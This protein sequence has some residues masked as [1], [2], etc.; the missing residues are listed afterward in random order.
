[1]VFGDV[2]ARLV[3]VD[4]FDDSDVFQSALDACM[5]AV[6]QH[7]VAPALRNALAE[8]EDALLAAGLNPRRLA[9]ARQALQG[10]SERM[11]PKPSD[12]SEAAELQHNVP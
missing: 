5:P 2:V 6:I 8:L 11:L 10:A 3:G 7:P 1:M 12:E 4:P 9:E